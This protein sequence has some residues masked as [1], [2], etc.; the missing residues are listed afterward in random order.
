MFPIKLFCSILTTNPKSGASCSLR[1][2]IYKVHA[3]W[4]SSDR[5][6]LLKPFVK[7]FFQVFS[8]FFEA[9]SFAEFTF[10]CNPSLPARLAALASDLHTISPA[11]P[12]VKNFFQIFQIF[13]TVLDG[14]PFHMRRSLK[15]LVILPVQT[16]K[17][18]PFRPIVFHKHTS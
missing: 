12:F 15:R 4:R 8:N 14:K 17:V 11:L 1:C 7:N 13:L 3:A 2:L 18:N 9:L 5:L 6:P 10:S 16:I